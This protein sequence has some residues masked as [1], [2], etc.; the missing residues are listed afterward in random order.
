M[1]VLRKRVRTDPAKGDL[2]LRLTYDAACAW[3]LPK[4]LILQAILHKIHYR[5]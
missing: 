2:S 3:D 1:R 4:C 5:A